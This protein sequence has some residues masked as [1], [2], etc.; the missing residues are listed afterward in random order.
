MKK[1]ILFIFAIFHI[2]CTKAQTMEEVIR[3]LVRQRVPQPAIVLAQARLES[4]NFKSRRA[5]KDH[6]ILGL[7]KA[8]KY[9]KYR[10]RQDCIADYKKRISSR[11]KGGDYY[12]FLK[13][14][15][16]A[17]EKDYERKLRYIVKTSKVGR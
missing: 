12:L 2:V 9:A 1:I 13:R 4:G 7:K 3:E 5:R 10:C 6:N 17:E 14:I 11:Y 16:Y 15:G 8:G